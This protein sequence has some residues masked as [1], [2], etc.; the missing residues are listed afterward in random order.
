[1]GKPAA[2]MKAL[3][4]RAVCERLLAL[5]V[6]HADVFAAMDGLKATL[7]AI[8]TEAGDGF[9]E[10]FPDQGQVT[11]A[12]AKPKEFKGHVAEVEPKVFDALPPAKREKLVDQGIIKIMPHFTRDFHGRVD[13]KTFG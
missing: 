11:V 2:K 7:I 6:K 1:M 8:A 5:R 4:R 10:V 3:D 12:A 13:V 9:R